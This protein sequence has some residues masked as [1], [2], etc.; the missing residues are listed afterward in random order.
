M[1]LHGGLRDAHIAG[2]LFVE[3]TGRNLDHDVALTGAKRVETL[4][5]RAQGFITLPA[6]TIA[7][8]AGLDSIAEILVTER[9]C[10]EFYGT[11]L[12]GLHGHRNVP[13]RCDEDDREL[14]IRR[15]K[16][17]L[18]LK[19]ASPWHSNVESRQLGPSESSAFKKSET[20]EN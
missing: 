2:N 5:E 4:P 12:H 19:T 15:G 3:A 11:A 13:V 1:H 9:F 20:D 8:K 7:R 16:V 14:F 6:G 18:K 10:E 17:T